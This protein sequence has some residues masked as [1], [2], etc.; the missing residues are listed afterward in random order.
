MRLL[1]TNFEVVSAVFLICTQLG[2]TQQ[3]LNSISTHHE[4]VTMR[5]TECI[6]RNDTI[7]WVSNGWITLLLIQTCS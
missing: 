1:S 2:S 7:K 4:G 5:L 6:S 3:Y